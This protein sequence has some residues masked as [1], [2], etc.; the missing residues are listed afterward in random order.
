MKIGSKTITN[1]NKWS[2]KDIILLIFSIVILATSLILNTLIDSG[3]SVWISVVAIIGSIFSILSITMGSKKNYHSFIFSALG[4]LVFAGLSIYWK[5][6]LTS[7]L[8]F[9]LFI[10]SIFG[11]IE[12]KKKTNYQGVLELNEQSNKSV[13]IWILFA[14]IFAVPM[15]FIFN[16]IPSYSSNLAITKVTDSLNFTVSLFAMYLSLKRSKGTWF[17]WTFVNA[18]SFILYLSLVISSSNEMVSPIIALVTSSI[19]LMNSIAGIYRWSSHSVE[20]KV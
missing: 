18:I 19:Y 14:I 17:L 12:W 20:E 16:L 6:Y 4:S 5:I 2:S 11:F 9:I 3:E 7:T 15:F 10:M 1:L 13:A 8:Q